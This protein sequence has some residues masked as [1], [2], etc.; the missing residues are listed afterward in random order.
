MMDRLPVTS[1]LDTGDLPV[2]EIA[3]LAKRGG[4]RPRPAYQAHKWFARRFAVT[5]RSL[6][7]ASIPPADAQFW[8]AYY[9]E[10]SC[11]QLSVL[12]PF[13]GGGV[14]LLEARLS[15]AA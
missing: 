10:A 11:A 15:G 4:R 6:I 14:W 13:W 9:G 12:D 2:G 1:L 7:T 8:P 3:M 5:A